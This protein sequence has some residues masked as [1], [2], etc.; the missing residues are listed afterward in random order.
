MIAAA[1]AAGAVLPARI[2]D[3]ALSVLLHDIGKLWE[4]SSDAPRP[5]P[6]ELHL[7]CPRHPETNAF[8]H[9]HAALSARFIEEMVGIPGAARWGPRHHL[10]DPAS[11]EELCAAL[12]DLLVLGEVGRDESR[13][14]PAAATT[15]LR[16][17]FGSL[18]GAEAGPRVLPLARLD[19]LPDAV[20]PRVVV[21][22]SRED[23]RFHWNHFL[24][25]AG[26]AGTPLRDLEA[27]MALLETFVSRVPA[28]STNRQLRSEPD[29]DL[30]TH[31]RCVA[32]AAVALYRG[33][34]GPRELLE[35]IQRLEGRGGDGKPP[36]LCALLEGRIA[37]ARRIAGG[38]SP[39]ASPREAFGRALFL[40]LLTEGAAHRVLRRL[41]LPASSLL[42][43][44][45][46][47]FLILAPSGPA[48][49]EA[50]NEV[51]EALAGALRGEAGLEL[52]AA[53]LSAGDFCAGLA[54]R[55]I[56]L[57]AELDRALERRL[58]R[59]ARRDHARVFGPGDPGGAECASCGGAVEAA[60][61]SPA[62]PAARCGLCAS[63]E[64]L[65]EALIERRPLVRRGPSGEE[66][67]YRAAL[68]RLGE[69]VEPAAR[70]PADGIAAPLRSRIFLPA[71]GDPEAFS[72][73]RAVA[74]SV[75]APRREELLGRL[76]G[77]G[78]GLARAL[79][80]E[81]TLRG[82]FS[83][84]EQPAGAGKQK[85]VAVLASS[86]EGLVAAGEREAVSDFLSRFE[87]AFRLLA[88]NPALALEARLDEESG[89]RI[90]LRE[91]QERVRTRA[92]AAHV[93]AAALDLAR[94]LSG[95]G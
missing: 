54:A 42:E 34:L 9:T 11:R 62:G 53:E 35:S 63:L 51:E 72:S 39:G 15:P 8:T 88:S 1:G 92:P 91:M 73:R 93:R 46:G 71:R 59:L 58:S 90:G 13:D 64:E 69:V 57:D 76:P 81:E 52:E 10:P 22:V 19:H 86:A 50:R 70:A 68:G 67:G 78:P 95:E 4:R 66:S 3:Y 7:Y 12:A 30:F 77:S 84:W 17:V 79:V 28:A 20:V 44:Q 23:Y 31:S 41:G 21:P 27:W 49:E 18:T 48:V 26:K 45:G 47:R 56:A 80:L 87:E 74:L 75:R 24:A 37:G 83:G 60:G 36:P 94:F 14:A 65:G 29:V 16:T 6:A 33:P 38:R 5:E 55:L 32:A 89:G 43:A 25:A 85:P 2:E 61:A 40:D 82:L